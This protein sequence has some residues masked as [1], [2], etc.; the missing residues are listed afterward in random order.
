[1]KWKAPIAVA[2]LVALGAFPAAVAGAPPPPSRLGQVILPS[3]HV[4][5]VEVA[6]TPA[7]IQRGYMYRKS[8]SDREGMVFLMESMDFHPFW[9]KNCRVALDIIWLDETWRVVHIERELPPCKDKDPCPS[10]Q[11][12]QAGL[13]VLEVQAGLAG[14]EGLKLGDHIIFSAP[15]H[16]PKDQH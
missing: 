6:D 1:M 4:L 14:R 12:L 9:M 15:S 8:V 10:H 5:Q 13:Y 3:G 7:E 16:T 2:T 11:P